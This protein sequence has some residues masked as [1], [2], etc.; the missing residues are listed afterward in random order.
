MALLGMEFV[1]GAYTS[2]TGT[3]NTAY[4]TESSATWY[5]LGEFV[6]VAIGLHMKNI[7]SFT[8]TVIGSNFPPSMGTV[9]NMSDICQNDAPIYGRMMVNTSGQLVLSTRGTSI[10]QATVSG[11]LM[12]RAA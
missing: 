10:T 1:D 4:A 9:F 11:I 12:Y 5:K 2:G 7:S 3:I 8:D 6:Y